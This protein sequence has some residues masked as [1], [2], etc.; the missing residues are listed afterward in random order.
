MPDRL[1]LMIATLTAITYNAHGGK[2]LSAVDFMLSVSNEQKEKEKA[3]EKQK[4]IFDAL[5]SFGT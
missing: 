4:K 1:E 5:D 2:D 3:K